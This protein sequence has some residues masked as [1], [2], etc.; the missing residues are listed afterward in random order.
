MHLRALIFA[1]VAAAILG[2][3]DSTRAAGPVDPDWPCIQRKVPRLSVGQMWAG[4]PVPEKSNAWR[5]DP[6]VAA[7]APLLAARRT[8]MEEVRTRIDAFA[9]DA[10]A[11]QL[12]LLFQG[13]F[14][15]VERERRRLI[16]GIARYAHKQTD[17]SEKLDR[18]R[19][20]IV[21]AREGVSDTDYDALDRIE[22]MEDQLTWDTR[23]YDERRKSL[24]YVCE[25]PVLMEKRVFAISRLIQEKL[26]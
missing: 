22:A 5:D 2:Q 12:T 8:D 20:E 21:A 3:I 14:D 18:L 17:L 16:D 10:S 6:A 15:L 4:P 23:V 11:E 1:G 19:D 25:S 26:P 13:V 24:T 9:A 7:L